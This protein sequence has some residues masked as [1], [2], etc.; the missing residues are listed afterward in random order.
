MDRP[1]L[2][3]ETMNNTEKQT[4]AAAA[5]LHEAG[6]I[7]GE[8]LA[9]PLTFQDV[10]GAIGLSDSRDKVFFIAYELW[11]HLIPEHFGAD[12]RTWITCG[13]AA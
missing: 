6:G 9:A 7:A 10:D 2:T 12:Y 11:W 13:I 4:T 3:A 8:Q 1:Q 5:S